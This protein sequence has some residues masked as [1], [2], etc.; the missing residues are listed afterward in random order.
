MLSAESLDELDVLGL[1]AR[2]DE[3]TQVRLALV[4][5][6]RAL[7]QTTGKTIVNERVLQDL[8]QDMTR[9]CW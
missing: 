5:C 9:Q 2:L 4:K 3:H 8:L 6:L 1:S 7:A